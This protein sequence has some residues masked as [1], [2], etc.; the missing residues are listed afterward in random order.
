MRILF[1][2]LLCVWFLS[3]ASVQAQV[4]VSPSGGHGAVIQKDSSSMTVTV[5]VTGTTITVGKKEIDERKKPAIS[6]PADSVQDMLKPPA[7]PYLPQGQDCPS[8]LQKDDKID[9]NASAWSCPGES[10]NLMKLSYR[11]G[12]EY[13]VY[14]DN[15]SEDDSTFFI[16][17]RT[18]FE[19]LSFYHNLPVKVSIRYGCPGTQLQNPCDASAASQ[20]QDP[21]PDGTYVTMSSKG[22]DY[23]YECVV[24][25]APGCGQWKLT[26][27]GGCKPKIEG[28]CGASR[29]LSFASIPTDNLCAT[30][31]ASVVSGSGPWSWSCLGSEG[32]KNETCVA[33]KV[34][35]GPFDVAFSLKACTKK[36][37]PVDV[38]INL[39][40]SASMGGLLNDAKA[41]M[42]TIVNSYLAKNNNVNLTITAFGGSGYTKVAGGK[43]PYG[44]AYG[45]AGISGAAIDK[46]IGEINDG[47][48]TPMARNID[49]S[50]GFL[51]PS[52]DRQA[53]MIVLSDGIETCSGNV[54]KSVDN[55]K[56]KGI[57]MFGIAYGSRADTGS[58]DHFHSYKE[59]SKQNEVL[60]ALNTYLSAISLQ[61]CTPSLTV[62]HVG[63]RTA[64]LATV[65]N[66]EHLSIDSGSYDFVIDY[67]GETRV[68]ENQS[69]SSSGTLSYDYGCD[70]K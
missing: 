18:R 29:G 8:P 9:R 10:D 69:V 25:N 28:V 61:E 6:L 33:D 50:S 21:A 63:D 1:A 16:P 56:L 55:A 30:G 53:A 51:T 20:S 34:V 38:V 35:A 59:A 46:A 37:K 22:K 2:G 47:N 62:Y 70:G 58:F 45:P 39:D 40:A 13:C 3:S 68:L 43:C 32:G 41:S 67:C 17:V 19:W 36:Y 65:R 42:R 5:P 57:Q 24:D 12:L 7:D 4:A 49:H 44:T 66:G 23:T 26:G 54:D 15:R 52:A 14:V 27:G 31:D 64:P 60:A 11:S 48:N